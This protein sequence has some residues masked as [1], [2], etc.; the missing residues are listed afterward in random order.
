MAWSAFANLFS[1]VKC[2]AMRDRSDYSFDCTRRPS[3]KPATRSIAE[4][5][6][7]TSSTMSSSHSTSTKTELFYNE[8]LAPAPTPMPAPAY[9]YGSENRRHVFSAEKDGQPQHSTRH[10]PIELVDKIANLLNQNDY[11]A[12][13]IGENASGSLR[14]LFLKQCMSRRYSQC[15]TIWGTLD[16]KDRLDL[17]QV[18]RLGHRTPDC[19]FLQILEPDAHAAWPADP[20]FSEVDTRSDSGSASSGGYRF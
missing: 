3:I 2:C 16:E 19:F 15:E 7:S 8:L 18:L 1:D 11:I 17:M 4:R 9:H 5:R 13:E 14:L 20:S 12:R 10:V 6:P